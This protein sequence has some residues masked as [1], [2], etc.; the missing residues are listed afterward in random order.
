VCVGAPAGRRHKPDGSVPTNVTRRAS[1]KSLSAAKRAHGDQVTPE[2]PVVQIRAKHGT[3]VDACVL[4][5][6][7][8]A[9][10]QKAGRSNH[11]AQAAQRRARGQ[12]G[13]QVRT[14]RPVPGLVSSSRRRGPAGGSLTPIVLQC[15][16]G[17]PVAVLRS[18]GPG[19]GG[20]GEQGWPGCRGCRHGDLY[21]CRG[22]LQPRE[23]LIPARCTLE[24]CSRSSPPRF[25]D[26]SPPLS[27]PSSTF[28][29]RPP[30][31]SPTTSC[32]R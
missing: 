24:T 5:P 23:R 25:S 22:E 2:L 10:N 21:D 1:S 31:R 32:S 17:A 26:R 6:W 27:A 8:A 18:Q 4:S 30:T 29:R 15:L 16:I 7:Y 19:R 14:S 3:S 12:A 9:A 20:E 13:Q 28:S 11:A